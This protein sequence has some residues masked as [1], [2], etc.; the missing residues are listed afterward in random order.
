MLVAAEV[1]ELVELVA[2][3]MVDGQMLQQRELL[4]QAVVAVVAI[5]QPAMSI[6]LEPLAVQVLSLLGIQRRKEN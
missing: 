5:I 2:V 6:G 1:V 3:E 4:T